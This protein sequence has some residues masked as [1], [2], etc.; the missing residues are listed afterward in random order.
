MCLAARYD[1]WARMWWC[2]S[3][4]HI[5]TVFLTPRQLN[6][7]IYVTFTFVHL[8]CCP[9]RTIPLN[10][11]KGS[12]VGCVG[13]WFCVYLS[14]NPFHKMDVM[15]RDRR[16]ISTMFLWIYWWKLIIKVL[17][18]LKVMSFSRIF[19]NFDFERWHKQDVE[20]FF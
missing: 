7:L 9:Y 8:V 11:Q 20:N 4:M 3:C 15:R 12:I 2:M 13:S 6:L 19:C 1:T 16:S 18:F 10:K 17:G 14:L 5:W